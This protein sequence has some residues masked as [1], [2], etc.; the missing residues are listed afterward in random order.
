MTTATTTKVAK[1]VQC[2]NRGTLPIYTRSHTTRGDTG[3][4]SSGH[5]DNKEE[6]E[7]EEDGKDLDHEPAIRRD[8]LQRLDELRVRR[9]HIHL[10]NLHVRVDPL[11]GLPLLVY[12]V[13]QLL[14]D[15][16]QLSNGAL[17][18][19]DCPRSVRKIRIL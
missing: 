10:R 18:T 6:E 19:L 5:E 13:G 14:E 12:E 2:K 4:S 15:V 11:H 1:E 8:R 9:L 16:G 17:D 3:G 7:G